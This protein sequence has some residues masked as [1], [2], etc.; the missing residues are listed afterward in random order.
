MFAP[1]TPQ[2]KPNTIWYVAPPNILQ[3]HRA[4]SG[5]M[6]GGSPVN[7]WMLF[8]VVRVW[9]QMRPM[10]KSNIDVRQS[11]GAGWARESGEGMCVCVFRLS[12]HW[13]CEKCAPLLTGSPCHWCQWLIPAPLGEFPP[14]SQSPHFDRWDPFPEY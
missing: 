5:G 9:Q 10:Y 6:V 11:L 2:F 13:S 1:E 12:L 4:L 8:F 3:S 14:F 7:I